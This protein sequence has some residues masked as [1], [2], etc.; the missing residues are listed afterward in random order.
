MAGFYSHD[1][2]DVCRP[3]YDKYYA[4]LPHL[5]SDHGFKY[6][7]AFFHWMLPTM[8][9]DD[10]HLVALAIVKSQ[11]PDTNSAYQNMLQDGLEDLLR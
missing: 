7:K 9:I 5:D 11:V 4:Y 2:L 3:Y 8:E 6:V 1:Q 10:K